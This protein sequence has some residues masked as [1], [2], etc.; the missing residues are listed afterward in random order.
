MYRATSL[1]GPYVRVTS[2]WI[3]EPLYLDISAAA[4]V[5]NFYRVTSVTY[6]TVPG[7]S[8]PVEKESGMSEPAWAIAGM[9]ILT[10]PDYVGSPGTTTVSSLIIANAQG[11]VG[12]GM[13]IRISYDPNMVRPV[14]QLNP[15]LPTVEKAGIT[16][17][18][19]VSDNGLTAA[20]ELVIHASGA[21]L[22]T[23]G[24]RIFDVL[25]SVT[26]VA[27]GGATMTNRIT[28]ATMKD[29]EGHAI[30][31]DISDAAVLTVQS[32]GGQSYFRGDVDGDGLLSQNDFVAV[33]GLAAGQR[34]ATPKEILA[35]DLNGNG[36]IDKDDAHLI[37]RL[38]HGQKVN[39]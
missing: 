5:T 7:T 25:W 32:L 26:N 10:M 33:M 12:D 9:V 6:T 22:I 20:G 27:S 8:V 34:A 21:G 2:S 4:G 37:L 3:A 29:S 39:P 16:S 1:E 18:L 14:S 38:F 31:V 36:E 19:V 35:G 17:G 11:L 23:G 28:H 24:G 15:A 13:E 30:P